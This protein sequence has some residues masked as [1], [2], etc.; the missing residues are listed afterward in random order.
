MKSERLAYEPTGFKYEPA[1]FAYEP[2]YSKNT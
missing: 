1:G 2:D